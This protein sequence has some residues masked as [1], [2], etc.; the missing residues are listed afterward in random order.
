[1][2]SIFKIQIPSLTFKI[3][4]IVNML[5]WESKKIAFF[6]MN[7]VHFSDDSALFNTR[8]LPSGFRVLTSEYRA[9]G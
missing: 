3:V 5:T 9:G 1:M 7:L 8:K 4:N 2:K 6:Y